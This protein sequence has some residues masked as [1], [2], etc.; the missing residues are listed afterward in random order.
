MDRKR[1]EGKCPLRFYPLFLT[2]GAILFGFSSNPGLLLFSLDPAGALSRFV[3][4]TGKI[5]WVRGRRFGMKEWKEEEYGLHVFFPA[6]STLPFP[7]MFDRF[8]A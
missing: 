2:Q 3:E 1:V 5:A 6:R 7:R 4:E 8:L